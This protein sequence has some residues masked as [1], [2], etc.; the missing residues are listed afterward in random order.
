MTSAQAEEHPG[1]LQPLHPLE[2]RLGAGHDVCACGFVPI[3]APRWCKYV[4]ERPFRSSRL[5][6]L[7][8]VS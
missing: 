6:F 7:L 8:E 1:G 2:V 4:S 5:D 3:S